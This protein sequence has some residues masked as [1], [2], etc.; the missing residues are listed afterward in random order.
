MYIY[1]IFRWL[2]DVLWESAVAFKARERGEREGEGEGG[3]EGEGGRTEEGRA[4]ARV[5]ERRARRSPARN[6]CNAGG[7]ARIA[8]LEL[9]QCRH[10]TRHINIYYFARGR[11]GGV[12]Q[13][14]DIY[15]HIYT[16]AHTQKYTYHCLYV[17]YVARGGY[18]PLSR[19]MTRYIC[20]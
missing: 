11:Y 5:W 12:A 15:V 8:L 6:P 3:T 10:V 20:I 13:G 14:L 17:Y 7:V 16:K 2:S 1:S 9:H 4:R 18:G 19:D